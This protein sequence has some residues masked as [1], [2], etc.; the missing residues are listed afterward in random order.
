MK[1]LTVATALA[2]ILA[3]FG[4]FGV[5]LANT[6]ETPQQQPA[7]PVCSVDAS[8]LL[9]QI[10]AERQNLGA[11]AL[12]IEQ[13]LST[14]ARQKLDDMV[15][16]K[17]YS[18]TQIGASYVDLIRTQGIHAAIA[19][20]LGSD[21][22][23]PENS[24]VEFKNSPSHYKSMIDPKY[25]RVGIAAQCTDFVLEHQTDAIDATM[26]GQEVRDLTVVHL[27]GDEPPQ[28]SQK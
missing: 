15:S 22:V 5:A 3:L 17:Y 27:A 10:N 28:P 26:V 20:N 11:P 12:L 9:E 23:T 19:E 8:K 1:K 24:W 6:A 4:A 14:S 16:K 13:K 2:V 21:D 7:T 18:H 25:T